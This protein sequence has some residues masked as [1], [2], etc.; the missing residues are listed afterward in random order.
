MGHATVLEHERHQNEDELRSVLTTKCMAKGKV[1]GDVCWRNIGKYRRVSGEVA[2]ELFDLHD[3]VD[4]N[5]NIH[6][7]W[8]D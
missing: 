3:L 5:E 2:M 1:Y 8:T 6:E 7:D 4:Y